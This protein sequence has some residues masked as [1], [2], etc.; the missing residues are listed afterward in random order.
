[1]INLLAVAFGGAAGALGRYAIVVGIARLGGVGFPWA[2]AV[3]NISGSLLMGFC[4]VVLEQRGLL[5]SPWRLLILV[6]LLGGF[7]TFSSFS[8]ETLSLIQQM[9]WG[10][11]ITN[12]AFNFLGCLCATMVGVALARFMLA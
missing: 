5:D 6:G 3:A 8:L 1:M 2:T 12:A 7:T 10:M 4:W 9:R 11:A